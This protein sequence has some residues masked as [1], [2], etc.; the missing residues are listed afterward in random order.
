VLPR[1]LR[2]AVLAALCAGTSTPSEIGGFATGLLGAY[3]PLD[4]LHARVVRVGALRYFTAVTRVLLALGFLPSGLKKVLYVRFTQLPTTTPV[5]AFFEA[6]YQAGAWY[7]F[8]GWAQVLAA[9]LLLVP[10]TAALGAMLYF[11]IAVNVAVV[12]IAVGFEGTPFVTVAMALASLYLVCWEYDKW[13]ALLPPL[14]RAPRA[15]AAPAARPYLW[16]ALGWGGAG[17]GGVRGGAP[18]RPREPGPDGLDPR[19]SA[20]VRDGGRVR[21]GHG[22]AGAARDLVHWCAD[23]R[24]LTRGAVKRSPMAARRGQL[25]VVRHDAGVLGRRP[26][27]VLR[28]RTPGRPAPRAAPRPLGGGAAGR[29]GRLGRVAGARRRGAPVNARGRPLA[30]RPARARPP[31]ARARA[32]TAR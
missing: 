25:R 13:R 5:G 32:P 26:L 23:G 12:T 16:A 2:P 14:G 27:A 8:V 3:A 10:R 7:R 18:D 29:R 21:R 1:L 20:A 31:A 15:P 17:R 30:G 24:R 9:V 28:E 6:F 4:R 19:R 22:L 11:P